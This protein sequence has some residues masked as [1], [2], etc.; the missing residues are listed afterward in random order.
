M[1]PEVTPILKIHT[2][3]PISLYTYMRFTTFS[4]TAPALILPKDTP[5]RFHFL[6]FLF[7]RWVAPKQ[8][9][10]GPRGHSQKHFVQCWSSQ[11]LELMLTFFWLFY[12]T[13]LGGNHP[14]NERPRNA[15][16]QS[17]AL[18]CKACAPDL[19]L[20]PWSSTLFWKL[21]FSTLSS[22]YQEL[23]IFEKYLVFINN[24]DHS[25]CSIQS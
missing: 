7:W 24:V 19:Q 11:N 14:Q 16:C 25:I 21:F 2:L 20:E 13:Y 1:L 12:F 22:F 5:S 8:C 3:N 9:S 23:V 15:S 4:G 18:S 17:W 6:F 10:G